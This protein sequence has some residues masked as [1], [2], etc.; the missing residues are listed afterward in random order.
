MLPHRIPYADT[1]RFTS[2]V[3]D[4]LAQ[5]E[6]LREL[7]GFTPDLSGL[8][9]AAEQRTFD[10]A[11]RLTLCTAL[12]EQYKGM[13]LPDAVRDNLSALRRPDALTIT[14]GH[15]LCLFGGP[16]YVTFKILNAVRLA[17][18]M[19]ANLG[20]PVL[21]VF[22]M[23]TEDHDRA[24]IDHTY[25]NGH[26]L[27]WQ[28]R[29]GGAVG[30]LLLK[31]IGPVVEEAIA[32]LG[33]GAQAGELAALLRDAYRPEHT[34]AK[35]TRH[36]VNALFGR[37]GVLIVDGDDPALKQRFVPH[38]RE[39]LLNQV[40]QR[41]VAHANA[42]LAQHYTVQAHA[43][44]IN[45]FHLCPG[46][47]RRIVL[48]G[49][50]YRVLDGGPSWS[51]DQLLHELAT[52]PERF[53]PNVLLRPVYQETILPNIAY[54]GGG[55][56]LAYWLQLRWLFQALRVPMPVVLLRTSAG[57]LS[58]KHLRQ[59]EE[60]GLTLPDLFA[61]P[62]ATKARVAA[63]RAPFSTDISAER[64]HLQ[65]FYLDLA[66]RAA[67]V[68]PSLKASA[69]AHA[70]RALHGLERLGKALLRSAKRRE[71]DALARM[72]RVHHALFP[73]GGLQERRDNIL[74]MLAAHGIGFLDHLLEDLDPLAGTFTVFVE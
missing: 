6:A 67:A 17:R 66:T 21:P 18:T 43:R 15:Q 3:E 10:P 1:R 59:W 61:P 35:A 4:Y 71:A 48:E 58:A 70:T 57:F 19:S 72:D 28:G 42:K 20:R 63:E 56:E 31:D 5:V 54:V 23:A 24:E 36:F 9:Q 68:D 2:L 40:V 41:T 52:R 27:H 34:L 39:E 45:L 64:D 16:L 12:A 37:F 73:G 30:E 8:R 46:H 13:A 14:T 25:F 53:S 44:E 62:D 22:W 55:G 47:R 74:P 7:Y 60:L 38:M 69:E 65:A 33:T 51:T 26:K 50:G 11:S 29:D 32:L 49:Q